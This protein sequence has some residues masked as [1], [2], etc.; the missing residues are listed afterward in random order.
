MLRQLGRGLWGGRWRG[1]TE[2]AGKR[3]PGQAGAG[4]C[5]LSCGFKTSLGSL[6]S[7][8]LQ[9]RGSRESGRSWVPT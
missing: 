4:Q 8:E 6:G 3:V 7:S 1:G 2:V 5:L 9:Q